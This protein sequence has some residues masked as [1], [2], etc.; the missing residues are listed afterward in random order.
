MC[1][2][3]SVLKENNILFVTIPNNCMDRLQPL[4]LAVKKPAK[5]FV[6]AEFQDWYGDKIC[7][8]LNKE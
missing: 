2:K 5:D 8:S 6:R 4:D 1:S 3:G 7:S